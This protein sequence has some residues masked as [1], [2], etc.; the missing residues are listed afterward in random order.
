MPQVRRE[1]GKLPLDVGPASIPVH[2]RARRK[3]MSHIVQPGT[4]A[5][6]AA[7]HRGA[8]AHRARHLGKVVP[9]GAVG[10]TGATFREEEGRR[11]GPLENAVPVARVAVVDGHK[12]NF[13]VKAL[14]GDCAGGREFRLALPNGVY[15][16][17][18]CGDMFGLWGTLPSFEWRKLLING[19]EVRNEKRTGAEFLANFY[20]AHE[21]DEDLPGQDLWPNWS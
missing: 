19:R 12:L 10:H 15:E 17:H 11:G 20:Y 14:T 18:L 6:T 7:F 16:V 2:E 1:F 5:V 21:D 9:G 13:C 8:E 3:P 4:V